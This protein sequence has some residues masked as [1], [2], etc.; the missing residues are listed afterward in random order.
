MADRDSR[1]F[2]LHGVM[3]ANEPLPD[4]QASAYGVTADLLSAT[5]RPPL[6]HSSLRELTA[7]KLAQISAGTNSLSEALLSIPE[8]HSIA[9]AIE[10]R[11]LFEPS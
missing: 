4:M 5:S 3:S 9:N 6:T 7:P 1:V 10:I 11:F 8:F 2:Q